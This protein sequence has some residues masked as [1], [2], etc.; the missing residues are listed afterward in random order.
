MRSLPECLLLNAV[1]DTVDVE[2][3]DLGKGL[4]RM[5]VEWSTPGCACIGKQDIHMIRV[6]PNFCCQTFDLGNL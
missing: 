6:L 1:K 4:G 5:L 2:V 3:H